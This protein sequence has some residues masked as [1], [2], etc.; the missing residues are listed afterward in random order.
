MKNSIYVSII[1]LTI[2]CSPTLYIP[3]QQV[4]TSF[5]EKKET[6]VSGTIIFDGFG[7]T[8][9]GDISVAH[10]ITN[11]WALLGK[12]THYYA[13]NERTV[14]P[15]YT[16]TT[17][18][19]KGIGTELGIGYFTKL[20]TFNA[21]LWLISGLGSV[22]NN[23][24]ETDVLGNFSSRIFRTALQ[25]ALSYRKKYLEISLSSRLSHLH[26]Y[27]IR[28][29]Y[30]PYDELLKNTPDYFF[31]EPALTIRLG[32][33]NLKFQ[34]QYQHAYLLNQGINNENEIFPYM[35]AVVGM[36]VVARM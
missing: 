21:E 22:T 31:M 32:M 7:I 27:S 20:K 34:L 10:S 35:R 1:F 12:Y 16:H 29:Q 3:N 14:G 4:V 15:I 36:G 18:G 9:G 19:G 25:P 24:S 11:H 6:C 13:R 33:K 2:S 8:K 5:N 26:Y 23:T 30:E 28:G 17:T